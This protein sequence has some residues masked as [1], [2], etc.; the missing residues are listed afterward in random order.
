MRQNRCQS[1]LIFAGP[2]APTLQI[3][4]LAEIEPRPFC[5]LCW[6]IYRI[7][8]YEMSCYRLRNLYQS[9][10]AILL[11]QMRGWW[12]RL[13]MPEGGE[14][15][16]SHYPCFK[17]DVESGTSYAE[18]R[19]FLDGYDLVYNKYPS[20]DGK[21]MIRKLRNFEIEHG[22]GRLRN[23]SFMALNM[24]RNFVSFKLVR[25]KIC[26]GFSENSSH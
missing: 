4:T 1:F 2:W 18:A 21:P 26:F 19:H 8:R 12:V 25:S 9:N 7:C 10:E 23:D 22:F 6:S 13:A 16:Q 15:S 14:W 20:M 3:G 24:R 11:V 5:W 17:L